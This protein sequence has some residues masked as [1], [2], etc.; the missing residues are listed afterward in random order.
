MRYSLMSLGHVSSNQRCWDPEEHKWLVD[1][2]SWSQLKQHWQKEKNTVRNGTV[3]I[4]IAII[5][6]ELHVNVDMY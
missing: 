4:Q 1:L 5:F 2:T 3:N 6:I